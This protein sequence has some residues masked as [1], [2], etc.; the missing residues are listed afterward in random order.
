MLFGAG[1]SAGCCKP[2]AGLSRIAAPTLLPR[3][4]AGPFRPL[5]GG[6]HRFAPL[7]NAVLAI[8]PGGDRAFPF[9]LTDPAAAPIAGYLA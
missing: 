1:R 5:A 9:L 3:G 8:V 4:I 2:A 6:C 7:P